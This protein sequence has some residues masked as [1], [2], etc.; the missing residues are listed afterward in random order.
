MW[1]FESI[2]AGRML[3]KY[4]PRIKTKVVII[5]AGK[6]H[7]VDVEGYTDTVLKNLKGVRIIR[8]EDSKHEVFNSTPKMKYDFYKRFFEELN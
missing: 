2:K 5:Q 3:L 8:Y 1:E 7:L 6:D 4:L